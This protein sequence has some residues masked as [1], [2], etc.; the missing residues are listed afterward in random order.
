MSS[1][2]SSS[3]LLDIPKYYYFSS[4]N[5]YSGSLGDFSYKIKNGE[6]LKALTWHG[7]LCSEKAVIENEAEFEKSEAGFEAMIKWLEEKVQEK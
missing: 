4:G 7:K 5:D 1:A 6:S 2:T 3:K